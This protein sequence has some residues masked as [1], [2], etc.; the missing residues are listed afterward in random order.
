MNIS[1]LLIG[2]SSGL[3][4]GLALV[5]HPISR[6]VVIGLIAGV[7]IGGIMVDG[8]EGYMNWVAYIPSEMAKFTGFWIAMFTGGLGG[9]VLPWS[10]RAPQAR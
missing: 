5:A 9:A 3:I 1:H 8:V 4:V 2:L 6:A 7:V 10:V